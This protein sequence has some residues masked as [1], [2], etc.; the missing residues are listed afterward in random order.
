MLDGL[1][2]QVESAAAPLQQHA[3][4]SSIPGTMHDIN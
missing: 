2:V 3:T 4:A 1:V